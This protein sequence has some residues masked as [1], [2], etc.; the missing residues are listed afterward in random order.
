MNLASRRRVRAGLAATLMLVLLADS[1]EAKPR[2]KRRTR[3]SPPPVVQLVWHVETL[4]GK[5]L[6]EKKGEAPINPASV[7][8]VATSLWAL[9]RL[10]PDYRFDTYVLAR[11]EIQPE[12]GVLAG[13]LV[14][15]GAGDVNFQIENAMLVADAL[16]RIGVHR[17][18]GKLVVDPLFWMGWEHGS[19]GTQRDPVQRGMV[20]AGRLRAGLDSRQWKKYDQATWRRVA[21]VRGL[22]AARPPQVVIEGGLG[23]ETTPTAGNL[24]L[25]HQSNTLVDVLRKFDCH[26]T[27]DIERLDV[28]AGPPGEL[29]HWLAER[30]DVPATSVLLQTSSGLGVNRV[31]PA[32]VVKILREFRRSSEHHGYPIDTVLPVA[33]CESCT[34]TKAYPRLSHGSYAAAVAAKT[35]TLTTTDGGVAVLAGFVSTANGELAFCVA[36]PRSGR[37]LSAAR[38]AIEDWLLQL[39]TTNGG[40]MPRACTPPGAD[41]ADV[42]VVT[43]ARDAATAKIEVPDPE[44]RSGVGSR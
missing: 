1:A 3:S 20:M 34:V 24:L 13:D 12:S 5:V 7:V 40:P 27:N 14:V 19:A 15:R 25:A 9:E 2:K 32:T 31:S 38:K 21:A 23:V 37:Y 39:I 44:G 16:N 33:G 30:I 42:R 26:S 18:R 8:K 28:T 36:A 17:V 41:L 35:G 11:G 6:N 10:G 22:D 43:V 29:G 4:D